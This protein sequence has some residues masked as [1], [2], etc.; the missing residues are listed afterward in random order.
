MLVYKTHLKNSNRMR[1]KED[2]D[3]MWF[4][5]AAA[6]SGVSSHYGKTN[7]TDRAW[8]SPTN[9]SSRFFRVGVELR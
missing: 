2:C 9:A 8:H 7:L 4:L 6:L 1:S 5:L 3:R